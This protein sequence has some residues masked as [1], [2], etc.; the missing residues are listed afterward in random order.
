MGGASLPARATRA[1]AGPGRPSLFLT[2]VVRSCSACRGCEGAWR[3]GGEDLS[4]RACT[5]PETGRLD[6][7]GTQDPWTLRVRRGRAELHPHVGRRHSTAPPPEPPALPTPLGARGLLPRGRK[8]FAGWDP[9][10]RFSATGRTWLDP[11]GRSRLQTCGGAS[12]RAATAQVQA[13][14]TE[15]RV[16][17]QSAIHCP[18]ATLEE[19]TYLSG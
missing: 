14:T 5:S 1:E 12:L 18:V 11:S 16:P 2:K 9:G 7:R 13:G 19:V 10:P 3:P 4:G 17:G 15:A 8:E 6:L